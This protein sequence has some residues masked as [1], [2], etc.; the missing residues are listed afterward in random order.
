MRVIRT[1]EEGIEYSANAAAEALRAGGIV[2]YPTDT[3]YGLGVDARDAQAVERLKVLKGRNTE[4]WISIVVRDLEM[5]ARCAETQAQARQL[6]EQHLPGALTLVLPA[7]DTA[8]SHLASDDTIGVRIPDEPFTQALSRA[9]DSPY[10]AT[11]ANLAGMPTPGTVEQ[12]LAQFGEAVRGIDL[13]I[14]DGPREGREPS[15][16]V[17]ML[18]E[19]AEI[20]REGAISREQLGL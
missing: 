2:L 12:I 3:L 15:T 8:L 20:L 16:V 6:I 13:V 11:S 9:F 1:A 10:T 19:K 18:G 5:L 14:D 7:N 4:K 17:R